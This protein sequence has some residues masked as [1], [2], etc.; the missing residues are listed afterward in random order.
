MSSISKIGRIHFISS[1]KEAIDIS[2][3]DNIILT[4]E[5][6]NVNVWYDSGYVYSSEVFTGYV[7]Y[8]LIQ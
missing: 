3:I 4:V 2:P 7:H 6:E 8:R 1:R 5:G